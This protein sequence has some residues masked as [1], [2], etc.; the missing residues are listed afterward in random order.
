M[1]KMKLFK[2]KVRSLAPSIYLTLFNEFIDCLQFGAQHSHIRLPPL[3][4]QQQRTLHSLFLSLAL[5]LSP[6][7]V[8][9]ILFNFPYDLFIIYVC[10][11][12]PNNKKNA[13]A[14]FI[15]RMFR[16]KLYQQNYTTPHIPTA[17]TAVYIIRTFF[18]YRIVGLWLFSGIWRRLVSSI[19]TLLIRELSLQ[20]TQS[21]LAYCH[22]SW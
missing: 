10:L 13:T 16:L 6:S 1:F 20:H 9:C 3:L 8:F 19:A 21:I 12:L 2:I 7:S 15:F 5:Y 17:C 18:S 4:K 11:P 14:S 22:P